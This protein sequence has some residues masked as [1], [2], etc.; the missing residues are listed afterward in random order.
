MTT[1]SPSLSPDVT[2]F[3][4]DI[5]GNLTLSSGAPDFEK[6]AALIVKARKELDAIRSPAP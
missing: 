6:A 4:L 5:V 2:E 3:L 1:P